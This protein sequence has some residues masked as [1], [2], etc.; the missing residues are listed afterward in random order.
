MR[1]RPGC[2]SG[3]LQLTLLNVAFDWLQDRF[4]F[5]K[6]ASC[7][8]CGCGCLLTVLFIMISCSI[9]FNVDWFRLF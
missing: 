5:G 7:S 1:D 3:L 6:G 8:G 4:G 2:L 9:I